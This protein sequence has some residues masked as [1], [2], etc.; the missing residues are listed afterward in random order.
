MQVS[1][2]IWI[3][4]GQYFMRAQAQHTPCSINWFT[5]Q[6]ILSSSACYLRL[7][8]S[9]LNSAAVNSRNSCKRA[10]IYFIR[11]LVSW[12]HHPEKTYCS[13][14]LRPTVI[15]IARISTLKQRNKTLNARKEIVMICI[16]T[17][18][19]ITK[20]VIKTIIL[21]QLLSQV[22][23]YNVSTQLKMS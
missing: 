16:V 1:R 4:D 8:L 11:T 13:T 15:M 9:C 3:A 6:I 22:I 2:L 17:S 12:N 20:I 14:T 21:L 7:A 19:G 23:K 5:S 18:T 10:I